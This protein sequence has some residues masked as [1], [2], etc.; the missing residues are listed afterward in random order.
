MSRLP[1]RGLQGQPAA[2]ASLL[3]GTE[4]FPHL[5]AGAF[6]HGLMVVFI[7]A[8]IMAVLAAGV[9]LLRGGQSYYQDPS[10]AGQEQA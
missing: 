5:I 8:T 6:H 3:T 7:A 9:S 4:F 2:R 10:E 1:V